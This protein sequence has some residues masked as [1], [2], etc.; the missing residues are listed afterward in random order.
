MQEF[1][2]LIQEL[3]PEEELRVGAL[4]ESSGLGRHTT[5]ATRLYHFPAG[6]ELIDS[7]G[8]RSFRL[9]HVSKNQLTYGFIEFRPYLGQCKFSD[10]RHKVEPD[11][12]IREAVDTGDISQERYDSFQRIFASQGDGR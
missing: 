11:C 3:L 7:P 5:T 2:L 1:L 6:G 9:G 10:C 8:V 12:A 4:S